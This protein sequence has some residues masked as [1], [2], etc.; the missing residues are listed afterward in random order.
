MTIYL[1][2]DGDESLTLGLT[3]KCENMSE[4]LSD[5]LQTL[6]EGLRIQLDVILNGNYQ[7]MLKKHCIGIIAKKL[8]EANELFKKILI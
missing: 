8:S 5:D 2:N 6:I 7:E 1:F 4:R 3:I